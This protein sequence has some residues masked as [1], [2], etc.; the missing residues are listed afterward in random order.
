MAHSLAFG[1]GS[2]RRRSREI[3]HWVDSPS[4]G[5]SHEN[6]T[7]VGRLQRLGCVGAFS[8]SF[9]SLLPTFAMKSRTAISILA[10]V[11]TVSAV[12]IP[13]SRVKPRAPLSS[14]LTRRGF[15]VLAA[16]GSV[17]LNSSQGGNL[18]TSTVQVGGKSK[19]CS[20]VLFC[21]WLSETRC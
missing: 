11:S 15:A 10:A 17:G 18:Y 4:R 16:G 2:W 21:L 12:H 8:H 14:E 7:R 19:I 20:G 9:L 13:V 1:E 3:R 5:H 6:R